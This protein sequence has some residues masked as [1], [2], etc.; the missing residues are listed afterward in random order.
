M[1]APEI[2]FVRVVDDEGWRAVQSI[3][4]RVFVEEQRCSP[5]D[6]WDEHDA[7]ARHVLGVI[8]GEPA[9][10]ARWRVVAYRGAPA[11]KLERFAIL[12]AHR[13]NGY[14]RPLVRF[15]V[16]EARRSGH[17]RFVLN[18]QSHLQEF[19]ESLGFQDDGE[20]F[21]EVGI[22]HIPMRRFE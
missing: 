19:Y 14:G 15:V 5:S 22:P 3:R 1:T 18:A 13:G 11:A 2:R 21:T 12:E 4:Q 9:A 7:T 16:E 8:E 17:R 6:E 20:R 10:C